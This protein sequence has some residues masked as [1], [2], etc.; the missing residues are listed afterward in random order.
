M[1]SAAEAELGAVFTNCKA[2]IELRIALEEMG[3]KQQPTAVMT[4]NSTASGF[5]NDTICQRKT[6]AIDMHFYWLKDRS[7][8]GQF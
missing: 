4:D 3:H 7:N 8:Q 2:V 5:V 6:R 1:A